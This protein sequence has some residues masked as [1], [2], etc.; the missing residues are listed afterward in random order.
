[1]PSVPEMRDIAAKSLKMAFAVDLHKT[2]SKRQ[3]EKVFF[4]VR[5]PKD[6]KFFNKVFARKIDGVSEV[7][8]WLLLFYGWSWDLGLG[9]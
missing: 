4:E 3:R 5:F 7:D 8:Y 9:A 1:M 6:G 2:S